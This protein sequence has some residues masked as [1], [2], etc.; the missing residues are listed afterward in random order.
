MTRSKKVFKQALSAVHVYGGGDCPEKSLT[1]IQLALN[2]SRTRSFLYVF[3]DA[4]AGD[5]RTVT[6]VLDEIQNKQSQVISSFFFF[7][8]C[9]RQ[10][11]I[12]LDYNYVHRYLREGVRLKNDYDDYMQ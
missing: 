2:V 9:G 1:G 10:A 5:H 12:L 3:T 11:G 6:K 8:G 4:T 7:T